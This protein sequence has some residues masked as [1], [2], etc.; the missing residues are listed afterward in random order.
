MHCKFEHVSVSVSLF[1]S[2]AGMFSGSSYVHPMARFKS[3]ARRCILV[4]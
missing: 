1:V 4:K 2:S 3:D